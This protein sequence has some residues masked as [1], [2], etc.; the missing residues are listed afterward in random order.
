[1]MIFP[2]WS[3]TQGIPYETMV[4]LVTGQY[5][6]YG[7]VIRWAAGTA[8]AGQIIKHL[9]PIASAPASLIPGLNFIPGL[10]ANVQ[11]EQ[12]KHAT[13]FNTQQLLQLAGSLQK[14]EYIT[15]QVLNYTIG[16]TVLSG[17]GLA[18]TALSFMVLNQKLDAIDAGLKTI[19]ADVQQIKTFLESTERA[20]LF[21]ALSQL[22][23]I[24]HTTPIEH[25]HTILHQAHQTF[26][27]IN[28]R[29]RELLSTETFMDP[30]LQKTF[31][32]AT[33]YEEY[34]TITALA[35]ARCMA[36]LGMLKIATQEIKEANEFWQTTARNISKNYLLG[37]HPERFLASDF[38]Q[39]V[40][41]SELIQWLD[42]AYDSNH[43]ITWLD[44]LRKDM[45]MPWYSSNW[46]PFMNSGGSKNIGAGVSYEKEFFIPTL[47]KLVARSSIFEGYVSQ[48]DFWESQNKTPSQVQDLISRIP[49]SAAVNGYVLLEQGP[50]MNWGSTFV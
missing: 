1:M 42:F 3:V 31:G 15:R 5:K 37:Q 45:N 22:I 26:S 20:R 11:L 44:R 38:A 19:Q 10:I 49:K 29:Y 25:R 23:K 34:F 24:D 17:L 7:G 8:N 48:Y 28:M 2:G 50:S 32:M 30:N 33:L 18:A 9:I 39:E 27:E 36:E 6:L 40:P 12:V 47:R 14:T 41:T 13:Q 46:M 35:N 4:G 16:G 21:S 43:G